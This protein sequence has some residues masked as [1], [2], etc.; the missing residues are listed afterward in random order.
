MPLLD[1]IRLLSRMAWLSLKGRPSDPTPDYDVA[2][3]TYDDYYSRHL[4]RA[5]QELMQ[6]LPVA[7]GMRV[8]DAACGTGYFTHPLARM[9]GP[10][11]RVIAVDLSAGMLARNRRQAERAGLV[12]I[13]F[14]ESDALRL[15]ASL[16]TASLDGVVC[17][18]GICYMDQVRLRKEIERVLRPGGFVGL[19][20]N[21]AST[22][23][24]V[25]KIFEKVLLRQPTALV[26]HMK[27]RLPT[28]HVQLRRLFCRDALRPVHAW[29]GHVTV[30][31]RDG[32]AI[33]DYMLRSGASAGF[34]DALDPACLDEFLAAFRE[35]ADQRFERGQRVPVTHEYCGLLALRC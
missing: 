4:G 22:L 27:L 32:Q 8:L 9:V 2:A 30:P 13:D 35:E 11:G 20:E 10:Q 16:D 12:Q 31:C 19:I 23:G 5:A 24:A 7:P 33:S 6:R 1:W 28:G 29:N 25:S 18:W 15:L 3:A 26:K 14:V 21:R 17:G 34:L